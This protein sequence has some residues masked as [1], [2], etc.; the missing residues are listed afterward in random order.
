MRAICSGVC[1]FALVENFGNQQTPS[2]V[3]SQ[4]FLQIQ[5]PHRHY[6]DCRFV[7]STNLMT[8]LSQKSLQKF[9]LLFA[10]AKS[11]ISLLLRHCEAN[12]R[13]AKA[14]QKNKC[15]SAHRI[16]P[17]SWC[18]KS[19]SKGAVV[20]PADFLLE[21]EKRGS[22]PKSEKRQLLAR[23]GSGA[24]GAALL[25]KEKD[26]NDLIDSKADLSAELRCK[27]VS[28]INFSKVTIQ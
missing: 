24:G 7:Q 5:K 28:K 22:P 23:R 4:N 11:R 18:K 25:R 13:F 15:A 3:L 2:L 8:K 19:E 12:H 6:F 14:I 21:S 17:D 9:L 10:F 20:P 26:D 1:D 27:I 16:S